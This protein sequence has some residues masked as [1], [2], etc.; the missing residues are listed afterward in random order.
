MVALAEAAAQKMQATHTNPTTPTKTILSPLAGSGLSIVSRALTATTGGVT[1]ITLP[2]GVRLATT[3]AKQTTAVVSLPSGAVLK[4]AT[5][6]LSALKPIITVQKPG[7]ITTQALVG[8]TTKTVT[9]VK[10]AVSTN[11]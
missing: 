1:T 9:L 4:P 10:S 11:N 2:Q 6:T 3:P 8:G 5:T 7:A